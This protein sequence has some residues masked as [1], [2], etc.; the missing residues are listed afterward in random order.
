MLSI[1]FHLNS[2][3]QS[4]SHLFLLQNLSYILNTVFFQE[5]CSILRADNI[6]FALF[7]GVGVSALGCRHAEGN[8]HLP[9]SQPGVHLPNRFLTFS[10]VF[11]SLVEVGSLQTHWICEIKLRKSCC[12]LD[13]FIFETRSQ[14]AQAARSF[15]FP[16]PFLRSR[17]ICSH[18]SLCL[19]PLV[20]WYN[21]N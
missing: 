19:I 17:D 5:V 13:Q 18:A 12:N 11:S 10:C 9:A 8:P 21:V 1:E 16:C 15:C 2:S 6:V 20:L 3:Y 4:I 7:S 14:I